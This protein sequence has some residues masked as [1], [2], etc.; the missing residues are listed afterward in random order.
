MP[1]SEIIGFAA[2]FLMGATLGIIGAGGSILTVP[3]LVYLFRIDATLATTY[4][5][6]L[7]GTTAAAGGF[8]YALRGEFDHEAFLSFGIPSV[9]SVYFTRRYLLPAVPETIGSLGE[10]EL[11]RDGLIMVVF[12][13]FMLVAAVLMIRG[14]AKDEGEIPEN[15]KKKSALYRRFF[16]ATEGFVIGGI[17][18]M[19]GAGG[20]FLIVPALVWLMGLPIKRAVSTSLLII[21]AKSLLGF[22][23]DLQASSALDW[24]FLLVLLG[25]SAVGIFVGGKVGKKLPSYWLQRG[26]GWFVLMAG[27]FVIGSELC[28]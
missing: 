4:S 2:I 12:A 24:K 9:I 8:R 16:A 7:V 1:W 5:L 20:G 17:T 22:V 13:G 28:A 15:G 18:G 27:L 6:V 3:I 23:G 21:A 25:L 26:F 19:V 10:I 14:K 11:T